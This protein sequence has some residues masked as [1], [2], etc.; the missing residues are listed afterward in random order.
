MQSAVAIRERFS[1]PESQRVFLKQ[2]L[3]LATFSPHFGSFRTNTRRSQNNLPRPKPCPYSD[4]MSRRHRAARLLRWSIAA[5]PF[6][7]LAH[8][9]VPPKLSAATRPARG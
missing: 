9:G 1:S 5:T 7:S 2:V 3:I 4:P 6:Q 8:Y